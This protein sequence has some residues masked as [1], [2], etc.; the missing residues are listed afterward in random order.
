MRPI[1][2][3]ETN[4]VGHSI[5]EEDMSFCI[6]QA[7]IEGVYVL[8]IPNISKVIDYYQPVGENICVTLL[9]RYPLKIFSHFPCN[10]CGSRQFLAW[11]GNRSQD[12]ES[13][14]LIRNLNLTLDS[15][16]KFNAYIITEIGCNKDKSNGLRIAAIT[17]EKID[18]PSTSTI[19]LQNSLNIRDNVSYTFDDINVVYRA[20]SPE[21]QERIGFCINIPFLFCN[22]LYTMNDSIMLIHD[23]FN[24]LGVFP[25]VIIIGDSSTEHG[26]NRHSSCAIGHGNMWN[27]LNNLYDLVMFCQNNDIY[28]LTDTEEN[29]K[30]LNKITQL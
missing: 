18:I 21:V 10:L 23:F 28:I 5:Y 24:I 3:N 9:N 8:H 17:I 19:L 1:H 2:F 22:G 4:I 29:Y 7:I 30:I 16:T 15:L 14:D 6:L 25:T 27:D 12:E 13:V 11:N 26:S 20:L